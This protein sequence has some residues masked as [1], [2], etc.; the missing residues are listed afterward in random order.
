M[1]DK[2]SLRTLF[3]ESVRRTVPVGIV[4]SYTENVHHVLI[5]RGTYSQT[6]F[7]YWQQSTRQVVMVVILVLYALEG[8]RLSEVSITVISYLSYEVLNRRRRNV[9]Y[10]GVCFSRETVSD[11]CKEILDMVS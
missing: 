7:I 10:I 4:R 2:R 1:I 8:V 9:N 11:D 3:K 5:Q 6:A